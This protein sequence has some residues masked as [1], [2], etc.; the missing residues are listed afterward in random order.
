MQTNN[1]RF[2]DVVFPHV[3]AVAQDDNAGKYKTLCKK[4]GSLVRNSGLMQTLAFMQAKGVKSNERHHEILLDHLREELRKLDCIPQ[5]NTTKTIADFADFVRKTQ[6]PD[7]M[8]LTR[9]VLLLLN[10][11]KRLADT[12]I[13]KEEE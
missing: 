7:Y 11:H 5:N 6:V 8:V 2:A 3:R 13:A 12:L 4:A 9:Q 10:W 1:Q